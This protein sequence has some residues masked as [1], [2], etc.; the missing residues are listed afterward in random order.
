MRIDLIIK[1]GNFILD[2]IRY[3]LIGTATFAVAIAA[4]YVFVTMFSY[5][6]IG[7]ALVAAGWIVEQCYKEFVK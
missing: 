5:V 2:T 6:F 4:T 7:G 3:L 1:G